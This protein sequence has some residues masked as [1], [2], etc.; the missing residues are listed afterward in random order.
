MLI[1]YVSIETIGYFQ[2]MM[3]FGIILGMDDIS[4]RRDNTWFSYFLRTRE[5]YKP[6]ITYS[7]EDCHQENPYQVNL[8]ETAAD[9]NRV[10]SLL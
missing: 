5:G 1:N 10:E 8:S 3:T 7:G 2:S 6:T 4:F 9:G